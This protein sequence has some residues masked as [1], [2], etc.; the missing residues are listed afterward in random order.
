[1]TDK[2]LN[3]LLLQTIPEA[4]EPFDEFT[5]WQEGLDTGCHLTFEN[6]LFPLALY[7]L[8]NEIDD[9]VSRIFKMI[10]DI[11]VLNDEYAT[12]VVSIS[13]LE[14]FKA[15]Y[16]STYKY[17]EFMLPETLKIFNELEF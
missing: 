3:T 7:A 9:L 12:G 16:P 8:D 10:N 15:D 5:S 1:M 17:S 14:P 13:F 6:V 4:K 11:V 2:E